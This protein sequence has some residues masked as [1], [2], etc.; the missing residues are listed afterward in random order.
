MSLSVVFIHKFQ[1]D[2]I[3]ELCVNHWNVMIW[4]FNPTIVPIL[5]MNSA[6][7]IK[8]QVTVINI[9]SDI[10]KMLMKRTHEITGT[11]SF[12]DSCK[13]R[14]LYRV[15]QTTLLINFNLAVWF[16]AGNGKM[17]FCF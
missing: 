2:S 6:L 13:R 5:K 14:F 9:N 15:L 10:A 11:F 8:L 12:I 1:S 4:C 7:V 16:V 3:Q 17:H